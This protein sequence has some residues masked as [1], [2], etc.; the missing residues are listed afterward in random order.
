MK[1]NNIDR[2]DFIKITSTTFLGSTAISP[3]KS[4]PFF[5]KSRDRKRPNILFAISDDQSWCHTGAAGDKVVKTP[6]FDRIA[7]EGVVFTHAFSAAPSCT[8]SRGAIFTGRYIW[9][10]EEGANLGG[11]L[12]NKFK[13]YPDLLE[14][15]GYFVGY[16]GKGWFPGLNEPGGRKRNPTGPEFNDIESEKPIGNNKVDY[17]LNFECFL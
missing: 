12:P 8:A 1:I 3:K 14:E 7:E 6:G 4:Y 5:L 2:R 13:V 11:T 15:T 17:A 10:L 9:E 16:T